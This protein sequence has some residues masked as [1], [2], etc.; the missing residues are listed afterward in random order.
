[1]VPVSVT[2]VLFLLHS[3]TM[4]V[5]SGRDRPPAGEPPDLLFVVLIPCLDEGVVID[6]TLHRLRALDVPNVRVLVVDDGSADTTADLVAAHAADDPR[7][8]LL[9]RRLPLARQGK[10][11]A[12][13]DAFTRLV[14]SPLVAGHREEDVVVVVLDADGRPEANMFTEAGRHFADPRCGAVQVGVRMYNVAESLLARMQDFEFVVFTEVYQRGRMRTGSVGLGGNGQFARLKALRDLGGDPWTECLT[15]DLDLGIRLQVL[16]WQ[17][18]FARTTY[19]AQQAVV[20]PRRLLRQRTRW[21]Q[22]HLQCL[23]RIPLI[24]RSPLTLVSSLDLVHHLL[25]PLVILLTSS[26]PVLL[27]IWAVLYALDSSHPLTHLD[28]VPWFVW[29]GAY[30]ITF[31]LAPLLGYVYWR[32][33]RLPAWRVLLLA[34][35]YVLYAWL[36]YVAGWWAVVRTARGRSGWA[37]TARTRSAETL[38]VEQRAAA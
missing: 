23:R 35:V 30:A 18:R 27:S 34:H 31:G 22:G 21:F 3:L 25:A 24:I 16:G 6:R 33:T 8:G 20:S 36:W 37:K 7:I 10:G 32:T 19:V 5:L 17:N 13:N 2:I 4:F 14:G 26:L 38:V 29:V 12:L 15:E 1:M 11:R 9:T 28:L